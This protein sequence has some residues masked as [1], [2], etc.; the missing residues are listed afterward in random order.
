[1]GVVGGLV[2]LTAF[3]FSSFNGVSV[4]NLIALI[5]CVAAAAG[6]LIFSKITGR[7]RLCYILTIIFV[8]FIMFPMEFFTAGGINSGMPVFF[9]FAVCY[10]VFLME[11]RVGLIL[12][13]IELIEYL[14]CGY[15]AVNYPQTVTPF[16]NEKA[17]AQDVLFSASICSIAMA[18]TMFLLISLYRSQQRKTK[19][20]LDEVSRQSSAKD[21]F[22]AN[23]S[24]EIR[25][26][27]N[28]ILGMSEMIDRT[29]G[30]TEILNFNKKIHVFGNK[31]NSLITD[32]FDMT[33]IRTG[34]TEFVDEPYDVSEFVDE[35]RLLGEELARQKKLEFIVDKELPVTDLIGDR[36][37]LTQV[38]SNLITNAVKYTEKGSVML[39]VKET[40]SDNGDCRIVFTVS[41]TGIGIPEE[42]LPRVFDLFYRIDNK[43]THSVQ[44]TGLGLAIVKEFTEGM[45]GSV[46]VESK[47]GE[48]TKFT[49]TFVQ[50]VPE[51]P[52]GE[53]D[54]DNAGVHYLAPDCH[55]LI[56]DDNP[57]N[58]EIIRILLER[59]MLKIDTAG[60][61]REGIRL[62]AWNPY[63]IIILDYMMPD[64][65]GIET[66][67]R[68][69]AQGTESVFI[70]LTA[71][72]VPGTNT[73]MY[74]AGFDEYVT[75]PVDWKKFEE[76]LLKH[77]PKEKLAY[78]GRAQTGTD[79]E[80]VRRLISD[81]DQPEIDISYGLKRV[82]NSPEMYR[83]ILMLF[84]SSHSRNF[85]KAGKLFESGDRE[86]LTNLIHSLKSQALGIGGR[87]LSGMA[88]VMEDKLRQGDLEY[89]KSAFP[90][91][92]LEWN[93]T[94]EQA[95]V[96]ADMLPKDMGSDGDSDGSDTED[97]DDIR[98]KAVYALKN[99]MWLD[100]RNAILKLKK[101]GHRD[102]D[103]DEILKM[104]EDFNFKGALERLAVL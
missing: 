29:S 93:R 64:M 94:N 50:K 89:V 66:L 9:V 53:K 54:E 12:S 76:L 20:A 55:I 59:T 70:V 30:E 25:T 81:I 44:G 1:M 85:E 43:Y 38:L 100:A 31:L 28:I 5:C 86:G 52:A 42:E 61:G 82:D 88:E 95:A 6:L 57:D 77:I 45:G 56:V 65:D 91:L 71:D 58:L 2:S 10:T 48:G 17:V 27:I 69:K 15:V 32:V 102:A 74:E 23:M 11:D 98:E 63:D 79:P 47:V 8:F 19:E 41:D 39:G 37:N 14:I 75:K 40:P 35:L 80:E 16:E 4:M 46:K 67:K 26:P 7:Y 22:L 62:A 3:I 96:I 18:V 101:A 72:A 13:G 60:S 51:E 103:Y 92:Q 33:K 104:T 68:L 73:K 99:N 90:L 78:V 87:L 21:L 36:K 84:G 34:Q 24:H 83:N 49:V 97:V